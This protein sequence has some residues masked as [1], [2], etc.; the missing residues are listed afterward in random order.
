VGLA[1][2]VP[3][4]GRIVSLASDGFHADSIHYFKNPAARFPHPVN[5]EQFQ[6]EAL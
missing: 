1:A 5:S 6:A 2:R 4:A 3:K